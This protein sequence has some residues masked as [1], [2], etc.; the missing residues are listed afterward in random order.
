MSMTET[1]IQ[2]VEAATKARSK[3]IRIPLQ[4]A[5]T[6]IVELTRMLKKENE[7]LEKII[8]MHE[9]KPKK[10]DTTKLSEE[11]AMDGGSFKS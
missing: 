3:E 11:I 1:F 6:L 9:E 8:K 2:K 7:L 5:Q 4:E 10:I